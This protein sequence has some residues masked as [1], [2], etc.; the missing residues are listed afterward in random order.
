LNYPILR[1]TA[2]LIAQ[3]FIAS[4]VHIFAQSRQGYV[5][6][7]SLFS[8]SITQLVTFNSS[9]FLYHHVFLLY[10]LRLREGKCS[11]GKGLTL[12]SPMMKSTRINQKLTVL[13]FSQFIAIFVNHPSLAH[14]GLVYLDNQISIN[15]SLLLFVK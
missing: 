4:L 14:C 11:S 9:F 2:H 12:L 13:L 6:Y 10:R 8:I 15:A 1:V 5:M 7:S 3:G